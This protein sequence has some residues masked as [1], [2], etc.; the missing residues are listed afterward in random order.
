MYRVFNMGVGLSMVVSEY[1]AE[2]IQQQLTD[3]G[4]PSWPIGTIVAG[5][6]E[7]RWG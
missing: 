1:Y 3:L 5:C 6:G 2:S 7:S 4:L